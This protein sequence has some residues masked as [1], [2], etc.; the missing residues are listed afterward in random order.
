MWAL[1]LSAYQAYQSGQ[2]TSGSGSAPVEATAGGYGKAGA[3]VDFSGF[4]VATGRATAHG[5]SIKKNAADDGLAG[6]TDMLPG[7]TS[8]IVLLGLGGL[9]LLVVWKIFSKRK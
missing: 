8:P 3:D 7:S 4:T 1:A 2:K 5:A 6:L 9:S